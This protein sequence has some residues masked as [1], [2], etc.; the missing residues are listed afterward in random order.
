MSEQPR[1]LDS[2]ALT[3]AIP[4]FNRA[5]QLHHVLESL[6]QQTITARIEVLVVDD[7]SSDGTAV[8]AH[9]LGAQ[10]IVHR[11][12]RG[13]AAARNSA[14]ARASSDVIA[15]LDD[16]CVASPD[17][18]RSIVEEFS[19]DPNLVGLGG[20]IVPAAPLTYYQ[21]YVS[22]HNPHGPLDMGL[23]HSSGVPYR[24]RQYLANGWRTRSRYDR[25]HVYA[26]AGGNMAFRRK[27]LQQ[28]GGF[29]DSWRFGA[30]DTELS[31]RLRTIY[32]DSALLF[33]PRPAVVHQ[34]D[35]HVWSGLP[36]ALAYGVG[37]AR[38]VAKHDDVPVRIFPGPFAVALL[39]A[40]APRRPSA[41]VAAAI[42]P[43]LIHPRGVLSARL[44]SPES[45]VD[46]YVATAEEAAQN[47]GELIGW[48]DGHRNLL[49]G[50]RYRA[51]A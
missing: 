18:A 15:F 9:E 2:P 30:E 36:K 22:R 42:L 46:A 38:M 5:S 45:V 4:T 21:R 1:T 10:V 24:L 48:L 6:R 49:R 20:P 33:D 26:L 47:L 13:P 37:H 35:T 14:L 39:L 27:A 25:R 17:W 43:H 3:V 32:G 51:A 19:R 11:V 23:A 41:L 29:D 16:D 44:Q 40:A 8:V 31:L 28:V 12:N 7:A 50:R 34:F